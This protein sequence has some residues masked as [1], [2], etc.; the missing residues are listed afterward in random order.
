MKTIT[1]YCLVLTLVMGGGAAQA[2]AQT[3]DDAKAVKSRKTVHHARK[4]SRPRLSAREK[5]MARARAQAE[6]QARL[7]AEAEARAQR[8]AEIARQEKI[9]LDAEALVAA[10]KPGA[11]YELLEPMEFERSGEVRYDYLLG[12]AALD[13]GKADKATLAFERV[14]AVDPDFAGARLDMARAYYQLGDLVRARTE[15]RIVLQANPPAAARATVN[16]Y[17]AAI[18]TRLHAR[19][20]RVAGYLEGTAGFDSN[21]NTATSQGQVA[22]PALGNLLFTLNQSSLKEDDSYLGWAG[23]LDV[24]HPVN[25][26]VALYARADIQQ[27]GNRTLTQF[28]TIK[29][30]GNAGGIFSLGRQDSLRL[31]LADGQYTLGSVRYYDDTGING[32][33]R[34]VFSPANQA[35]LFVQQM[36]YRFV[37]SA[38]FTGMSAQNFDQSILGTS[39]LHVMPDGRSSAYG[40]LFLG[41][42]RD[43]TGLRPDG[44]KRFAGLRAGGQAALLDDLEFFGSLGWNRGTYSRI[45]A[46]FLTTRRDVLY[47]AT[48]G[49]NWHWNQNWTVRPQLTWTHNQSN[50]AIYGYDRINASISLRRDFN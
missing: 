32:E 48:A 4:S 15:F 8:E 25:E 6:Q 47:D 20:T 22:V 43:V 5:R 16:K 13:S 12:I 10:G 44:D 27:R 46:L 24:L 38:R 39:W 36:Q 26:S 41:Q 30:D 19:D 49:F 42:E 9:M 40:S 18:E 50:I 21:V 17:L 14:L 29:V 45:N 31:G 3:A 34:H 33:W 35:A 23:G 37:D 7:R 2:A 1:V 28:D 11:A